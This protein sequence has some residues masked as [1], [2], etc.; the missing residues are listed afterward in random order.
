MI[1]DPL[2]F[3]LAE[4][5]KHNEKLE[6]EIMGLRNDIEKTKAL[7]LRFSKGSETLDEL[8]KVQ[9]SPLI[10]TGLGYTEETSQAQKPSTSKTYLEASRRN[11]Q[12]DNR[13]QRH[14]EDHQVNQVQF[15]SRMNR[16]HQVNRGKPTSRMNRS[17]NQPQVNHSYFASRMNVYE[18]YNHL[19]GRFDNRRNFFNGQFLSCHNFAHKVAQCVS[20]KT[21][22]TRE[23]QN[24][25][26]MTR[27]M[28][29]TYNNF[30][31]LE[32]EIE[33][34]ICNNFGHE[35]FECRSRFRQTT[36][37]EQDSLSPKTWRNK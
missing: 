21:I 30:S 11:E 27:I 19:D 13:Q 2:T 4:R 29:R 25:R 28:K 8:I 35:D 5:E 3:Q 9:C 33:C 22:M 7:N 31:A 15:T 20:Y 16:N 10:K 36:Q 26:S 1:I 32:N 37:K 12:V 17:Y 18:N 24:Q 14:N 23:A 34:F 6:C